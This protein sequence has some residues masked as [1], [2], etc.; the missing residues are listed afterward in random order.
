M[1][2]ME[3]LKKNKIAYFVIKNNKMSVIGIKAK[4]GSLIIGIAGNKITNVEYSDT[5]YLKTA[6]EWA[7]III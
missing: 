1:K 6:R 7:R 4:D 5:P 3:F 2:I